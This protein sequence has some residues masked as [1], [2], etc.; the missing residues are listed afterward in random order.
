MTLKGKIGAAIVLIAVAAPVI[1]FGASRILRNR[2]EARFSE[3]S[4]GQ[5]REELLA[6]LGEPSVTEQCSGPV[7]SD[8]KRIVGT[9]SQNWRYA[10][11]IEVWGVQV[12]KD[13]RVLNKY[14]NVS[15]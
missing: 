12:D 1:L 13:G 14:Y 9:C 4:A 2:F 5:T 6:L 7:Y 15:P 11:F 3:V 10:G 8:E